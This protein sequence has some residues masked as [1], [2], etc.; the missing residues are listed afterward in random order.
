MCK[1]LFGI[2]EELTEIYETIIDVGYFELP[3]GRELW[4]VRN[5]NC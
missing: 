4:D 1:V 2:H 5:T 3:E